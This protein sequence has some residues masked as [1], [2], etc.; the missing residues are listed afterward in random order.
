[1]TILNN[2]S[3]Q[4]R[5]NTSSITIFLI[6]TYLQLSTSMV[7]PNNYAEDKGFHSDPIF[8]RCWLHPNLNPNDNND[9]N[10]IFIFIVS[11]SLSLED[12]WNFQD[13][14]TWLRT[15]NIYYKWLEI[16]QF[17]ESSFLILCFCF[18]PIS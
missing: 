11:P 10:R 15:L 18:L 8:L 1:M 2:L 12:D 5:L 14:Y 7:N 9:N 6:I 17:Q 16:F 13:M 4:N 3:L